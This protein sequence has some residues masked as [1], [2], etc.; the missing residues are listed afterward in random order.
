MRDKHE[1]ASLFYITHVL[2]PF[3]FISFYRLITN[4]ASDESDPN[5]FAAVECCSLCM[6]LHNDALVMVTGNRY[7]SSI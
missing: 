1:G 3:F 7:E 2:V 5:Y 4:R 6:T